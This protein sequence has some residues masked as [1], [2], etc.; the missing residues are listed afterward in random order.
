MRLSRIFVTQTL[1]P[2][3]NIQLEPAISHYVRHVLRLKAGTAIALFNADDN[4]DYE[5][6]LSYQGKQT[7]ASIRTRVLSNCESSLSSEIVQGLSRSDHMDWMV[8]K[9]TELGVSR[10]SVFNAQHTQIPLKPG[11]LEKRLSHWRAVAVNACEQCERHC[12]PEINFDRKLGDVLSHSFQHS[13]KILLSIDG[14]NL[15]SLLTPESTEKQISLLV[16][17]E[18]GLSDTE[19]QTAK[20][21]GFVSIR[22]GP[23]VLRTETAAISA[24]AIIQ[25]LWGDI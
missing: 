8:Q 4:Y 9:S 15:N 22:L 20:Q 12:P 3:A 13:T 7:I 11:Q 5:S 21:A 16:G 2:G 10:I 19:I 23:R 17:P 1:T 14:E 24:L 25:S 18:G 6:L